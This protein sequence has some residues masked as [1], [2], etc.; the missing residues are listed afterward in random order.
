MYPDTNEAA[1][2]YLSY[3]H[4][5]LISLTYFNNNIYASEESLIEDYNFNGLIK[6]EWPVNVLSSESIELLK[7]FREAWLDYKREHSYSGDY[8]FLFIDKHWNNMIKEYLYPA[9]EKMELEMTSM[10]MD[11]IPYKTVCNSDNRPTDAQLLERVE[12]L[13]DLLLEKRI[14]S[15]DYLF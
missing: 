15:K 9:I 10:N 2:E 13:Y 3:I 8:V 1:R 14:I 7:T 4:F 6:N 5:N 11:Y 12:Q